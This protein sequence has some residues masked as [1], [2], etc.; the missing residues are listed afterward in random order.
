[1]ARLAMHGASPPVPPYIVEGAWR[2]A[3]AAYFES[4]RAAATFW[5]MNRF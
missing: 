1:M 5:Y 2:F 3:A 4:N